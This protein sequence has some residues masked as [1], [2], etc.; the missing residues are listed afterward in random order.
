MS[1]KICNRIVEIIFTAQY[2][3][4]WIYYQL[5]WSVQIFKVLAF[6]AIWFTF[7]RM[8]LSFKL[9]EFKWEK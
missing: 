2:M 4:L 7:S 9:I 5:G 8:I 1:I 3:S 6:E